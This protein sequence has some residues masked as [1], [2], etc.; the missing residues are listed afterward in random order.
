MHHSTYLIMKLNFEE[1]TDM[2]SSSFELNT[3]DL[4]VIHSCFQLILRAA[5]IWI[6]SSSLLSEYSC[7]RV[8][9]VY[10]AIV[11]RQHVVLVPCPVPCYLLTTCL[12]WF[13]SAAVS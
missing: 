7:P 4:L 13:L 9:L 2:S 8:S 10:H 3:F 1:D 6:M 12:E 5:F 11:I